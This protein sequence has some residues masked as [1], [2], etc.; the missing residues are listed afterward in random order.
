[1]KVLLLDAYNLIH[2]ARSGYTKGDNAIVYNFFR[3]VRPIIEKFNADKVYFILEGYPKH[4]VELADNYKGG[5]IDPGDT[6]R[7]QKDIIIDVVKRC[8]P[9]ISVR[10][11]DFECDDVIAT[12]A[13]NHAQKGDE[14]IIVSSDSDFIQLHNII[15][16]QLYH[17]IKKSFIEKPDYDYVMWKSLCGD[18]TDNVPGIRGVGNKTA[19]KLVKDNEKLV[20]FL[21][22][23]ENRDIFERNVNLI[24][25]VNLSGREGE[26]E[27]TRG[28]FNSEILKETFEAFEFAS[29]VSEKPW[30]KYCQTFEGL[31]SH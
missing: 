30:K 2:R 20:Q 25:L 5:R 6:F 16:V 22:I 7:Q 27:V 13:V 31:Q 15:N 17:P 18:K 21:E 9:F 14:C 24:R 28:A 10:H 12:I 11:P 8:L 1:L 29:M 19:L 4:R 23:K 26:F 3:G